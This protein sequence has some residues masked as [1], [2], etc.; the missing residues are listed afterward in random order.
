MSRRL[1]RSITV[2][3]IVLLGTG[4]AAA[5]WNQNSGGSSGQPSMFGSRSVGSSG[6]RFTSAGITR[7]AGTGATGSSA[8]MTRGASSQFGGAASQQGD[9]VGSDSRDLQ[10]F[11][12]RMNSSAAGGNRNMQGQNR[13]TGQGLGNNQMNQQSSQSQSANDSTMIRTIVRVGFDYPRPTTKQVARSLQEQFARSTRIRSLGTIRVSVQDGTATLQG[14]V[15]TPHDRVLAEQLAR[16]EVGIRQV[17][18]RLTVAPQ[19]EEPSEEDETA[20]PGPAPVG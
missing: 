18:N 12:S 20:K 8:G 10:N 6:S 5:Q 3:G 14:T 15:A 7:S 2:A 17:D 9:F 1:I 11:L 13:R 19:P 16:L 4:P